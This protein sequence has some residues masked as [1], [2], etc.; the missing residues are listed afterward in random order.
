MTRL[1]A[2]MKIA[3]KVLRQPALKAVV[4][5]EIAP[6]AADDLPD[7]AIRE[8]IVRHAKTVYHPSGTCRM[9]ADHEA[10]VGAQL[11]VHG[12][13]RLRICDASIMPRLTSGN[14]NAPVIMIADRCADFILGGR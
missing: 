1:I 5:E 3:R 7:E 14:T 10:V 13:P 9:G 2:G 12:V 11:R 4:R 6:G 8:H